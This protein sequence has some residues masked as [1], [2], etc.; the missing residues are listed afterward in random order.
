MTDPRKPHFR[1]YPGAYSVDAAF[2]PSTDACGVC[3]EPCGWR[4]SGNIYA[5]THPEIVCAACIA[6][7]RLLAHVGDMSLQDVELDDADP[8]LEAELMQRTP[9]VA[10]FNPFTWPVIDGAPLAFVG[11][12]DDPALQQIAAA[13]AAVKRAAKEIGSDDCELPTPYALIFRT[14]DG[15]RYE[16]ALDFD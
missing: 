6:S 12:G 9:G 10:S 5:V 16:A 4:Y 8:A 1:F 13:R 3:R 15:E 14:L 11:N 2:V 7:G